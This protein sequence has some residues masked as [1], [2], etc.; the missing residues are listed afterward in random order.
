MLTRA[1]GWI[2]ICLLVFLT[3]CASSNVQ[4]MEAQCYG[5]TVPAH[6]TS[7]LPA[8]ALI[9]NSNRGLLLLLAEYESLRRRAN[10]DRAAVV[11]IVGTGDLERE[12]SE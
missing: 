11:E 12:G 5:P 10:A 9:L 2:A 1:N 6:L 3:G 8:P 7:E 4:P